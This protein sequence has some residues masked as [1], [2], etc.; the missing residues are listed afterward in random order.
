MATMRWALAEG[1]IRMHS[2]KVKPG[3]CAGMSI[4]QSTRVATLC[5]VARSEL[6]HCASEGWTVCMFSRLSFASSSLSRQKTCA[7]S[8]STL[9]HVRV[10]WGRKPKS[11]KACAPVS[12]S[13]RQPAVAIRRGSV[14][15]RGRVRSDGGYTVKQKD[16]ERVTASAPEDVVDEG[17]LPGE[18]VHVCAHG[19]PA[20]VTVEVA[21][22]RDVGERAREPSRKSGRGPT[23]DDARREEHCGGKAG[24]GANLDEER[25]DGDADV[26]E[27][28]RR[29]VADGVLECAER[30]NVGGRRGDAGDGDG[31]KTGRV[32]APAAARQGAEEC[33]VQY[34]VCAQVLCY[35]ARVHAGAARHGDV[36]GHGGVVCAEGGGVRP[37]CLAGRLYG[38]PR[39]PVGGLHHGAAAV[40]RG[41]DRVT[42]PVVCAVERCRRSGEGG[43]DVCSSGLGCTECEAGGV[44]CGGAR[45]GGGVHPA[46]EHAHAVARVQEARHVRQLVHEEGVGDREDVPR[47]GVSVDEQRERCR[48]DVAGEHAGDVQRAKKDACG[49][50]REDEGAGEEAHLRSADAHDDAH[51]RGVGDGSAQRHAGLG[52]RAGVGLARVWGWVSGPRAFKCARGREV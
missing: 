31:H 41:A 34:R 27:E 22:E 35:E 7:C 32:T 20:E 51:A 5:S 1:A 3:H 40:Q 13:T 30:G 46:T 33:G 16:L 9:F 11:A 21:G 12:G 26:E 19:L 36:E 43:H 10:Y 2:S 38:P 52:E 17:R 15:V 45:C 23:L 44:V 47:R 25:G 42:L 48:G 39:G 49:G 37:V 14:G 24:P 29:R 6:N 50:A 8:A 18:C 4:T 28:R